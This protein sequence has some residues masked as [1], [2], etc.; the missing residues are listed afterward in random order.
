[1]SDPSH[2]FDALPGGFRRAVERFDALA[3]AL[4]AGADP[5]AEIRRRVERVEELC[6]PFDA[7]HLLGH[8]IYPETS[9]D[10][11]DYVESEHGGAAFIV[12]LAAAILVARPSREGGPDPEPAIGAKTTELIRDLVAEIA[13][14][15][16]YRRYRRL[17]TTAL[18]AAQARTAAYN[19][20]VRG[21]SWPEQERALLLDLFAP[22][23]LAEKLRARLGFDAAQAVACVEALPDL[24]RHQLSEHT[25]RAYEHLDEAKSW[26]PRVF[27]TKKQ[28]DQ[29]GMDRLAVA[30]WS[31]Q[32]LGEALVVACKSLASA[33]AVPVEVAEAVAARLSS[34]FGQSGDLFQRAETIRHRPYLSL[35]DGRFLPTALGNDLWALRGVFQE[36]LSDSDFFTRHRGAWLEQQAASMLER[37][38]QPDEA[39]ERVKIRQA[40]IDRGDIDALLRFG[41]TIIT[42]EAKSATMRPSARRGGDAL[43]DHLKAVV[44]KTSEQSDLAR[45]A[46]LG[47]EAVEL[48]DAAGKRL[49]ITGVREVQPIVVTLDDVSPVAP[50]LWQLIGSKLL[51]EGAT[52]PWVVTLFELDLVCQTV[53][54][55]MQ[56]IHF[57]R[58]RARLNEIG[59]LHAADELD[60]WMLYLTQGLYFEDDE[61]L[62]SG[63]VRYLSQTDD[64]DAWYL[65]SQGRR[66]TPAAKPRQALEEATVAMLDFLAERRPAGWVPAG[67]TLLELSGDTREALHDQLGQGRKRAL[68]R[69]A[70]QRGTLGFQDAREPFLICWVVCPDSWISQLEAQLRQ[71]VEERFRQLGEQRT[72]AIGLAAST[73]R[74]FD[75]M[76]VVEPAPT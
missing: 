69:G 58:R 26:F 46:L 63:Q 15:E 33:A 49:E 17:A 66:T 62:A 56:L 72:L 2:D 38:L 31:L 42:I 32:N 37:A 11:E 18:G 14:L 60:W 44:K 1:M 74:P 10:P 13:M 45:R 27:R 22:A 21:P 6:A 35:G 4:Q 76:L 24:V 68:E 71:L 39:L 59:G 48:F 19:L 61:L 67:C 9:M 12:E 16:G 65:Y 40:G 25:R 70:A 23:H 8:F 5:S 3:P 64:L 29:E 73:S 43:L 41:D 50:L 75:A 36:A 7:V 28:L 20:T 30:L 53:Q 52:I 47:E 54:W 51:P 55:P 57:L 34:D